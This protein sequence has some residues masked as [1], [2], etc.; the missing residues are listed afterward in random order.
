MGGR[1]GGAWSLK[2]GLASWL[3]WRAGGGESAADADRLIQVAAYLAEQV[4]DR[5]A[6]ILDLGCA[7]GGLLKALKA[8]WELA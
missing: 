3:G 6:R 7:N 1:A 2:S 5:K 4:P 8:T